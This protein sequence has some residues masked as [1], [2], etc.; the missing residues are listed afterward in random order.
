MMLTDCVRHRVTCHVSVAMATLQ[1][2]IPHWLIT[3][4]LVRE[5]LKA[6]RVPLASKMFLLVAAAM[7]MQW[8]V[9][10]AYDMHASWVQ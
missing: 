7:S 1:C 8:P 5:T 6:L 4:Q 9:G 3:S 2:R 10:A